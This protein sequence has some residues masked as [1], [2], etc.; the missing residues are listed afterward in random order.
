MPT[1]PKKEFREVLPG[2]INPTFQQPV[3]DPRAFGVGLGGFD[4]IADALSAIGDG[5]AKRSLEEFE[6]ESIAASKRAST[7]LA[8]SILQ[9]T[10]GTDDEPGYLSRLGVDALNSEDTYAEIEKERK[11]LSQTLSGNTRAQ[12]LFDADS[13]SQL[14]TIASIIASHRQTQ[15]K[16]ASLDAIKERKTLAFQLGTLDPFNSDVIAKALEIIVESVEA[17][18]RVLGTEPTSD[19]I[20]EQGRFIKEVITTAVQTDNIAARQ[21][22]ADNKDFVSGIVYPNIIDILDK[23]DR[24]AQIEGDRTAKA[25]LAETKLRHEQNFGDALVAAVA[26]GLSNT[27]MVGLADRDDISASQFRQL[28]AFNSKQSPDEGD[29]GIYNS[30]LVLTYIGDITIAEIMN[31]KD[32]I[33]QTQITDLVNTFYSDE[34]R[35]GIFSRGDVKAALNSIDRVVGGV[36]GPFATLTGSAS[37]K[38]DEAIKEFRERVP[39]MA[40]TGE[41]LEQISD[42]INRRWGPRSFDNPVTNILELPTPLTWK[43]LT[44]GKKEVLTIRWKEA[45]K[46]LNARQLTLDPI[47]YKREVDLL[48][49]FAKEI[50]QISDD[51]APA[52]SN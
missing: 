18:H 33:D 41:T 4:S 29:T 23:A 5:V 46:E 34:R 19:I 35:D 38:L 27:T 39:L 2:S 21:L 40:Q 7:S 50:E 16:V 48:N 52:R 11:R 51:L 45:R 6:T 13:V 9:I 37:L 8:K 47:I 15:S 3:T 28:V 10:K 14:L 24:D 22:F 44:V 32:K 26:G 42:D 20:R 43:G 30:A 17:E 31:L 49:A 25:A 1:V 12:S 36:R